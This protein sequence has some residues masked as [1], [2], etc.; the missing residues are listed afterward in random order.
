VSE[1]H[2]GDVYVRLGTDF[3]STVV[4]FQQ[5]GIDMRPVNICFSLPS[6]RLADVASVSL[7]RYIRFHMIYAQFSRRV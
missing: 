7:A 6:C 5:F 1:Q 4:A 2:V 3:N